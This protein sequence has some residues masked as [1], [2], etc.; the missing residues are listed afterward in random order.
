MAVLLQSLAHIPEPVDSE[1]PKP[2][3]PRNPFLTHASYPVLPL[4]H[5]LESAAVFEKLDVD[6]LFFVFYYQQGTHQQSLAARQLKRHAWRFHKKY[7][8]WFQRH[9]EPTATTDTYEQGAYVYFD[10]ET[11]WVQRVKR[12][13]TFEYAFLEDELA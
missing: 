11:G 1:R 13:F 2:Y 5:L 4:P 8:T 7:L 9:E 12:D 3:V 6:T 10:F